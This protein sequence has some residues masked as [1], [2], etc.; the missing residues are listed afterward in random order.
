VGAEGRV[1]WILVITL[2]WHSGLAV[3]SVPGFQSQEACIA[4]AGF[5]LQ[6]QRALNNYST[7]DAICV[8][9]R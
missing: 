2:Y 8:K 5:W 7:A 9:D 4:A 1:M 6:R 3:S